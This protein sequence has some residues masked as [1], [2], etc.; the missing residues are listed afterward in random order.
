MKRHPQRI[1]WTAGVAAA[2][3]A[4]VVARAAPEK[5]APAS[6]PATIRYGKPVRIAKLANASVNESSG[7]A[8]GQT[9]EG[10]FWTHNDSGDSPTLYA[11]NR[12]GEHLATLNIAGAAARDWEDMCSFKLAGK[13]VLL[14][15]D[16]GDNLRIR[17]RCTL[18]AVHEPKLPARPA[19]RALSASIVQRVHFR[20]ADGAANCE[21]IGFDPASRTVII[22][23]KSSGPCGVYLLPWPTKPS[24]R[25]VA[26][27]SVATLDL[28]MTTAMDVS[29]DGRRAVVLTYGDAYEYTRAAKQ[30]WADAFKR[31]GRRIKMP[32][33]GQGE[34]ICY[35][36]DGR[37]LYLTSEGT[38]TPL[39]EVPAAAPA[40]RPR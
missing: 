15:G 2:A 10:V 16:V 38:A 6:R 28:P 24:D 36:P 33:R 11:F 25:A 8:A 12:K 29:P 26:L 31:K 9:N 14:I 27:E 40:S 23:T 32:R 17:G 34:S 22:V 30:T 13:G 5:P 39:W 35:G 7:V 37:S 21:S 3:L 4:V 19:R 20:Y 18:Y 1:L